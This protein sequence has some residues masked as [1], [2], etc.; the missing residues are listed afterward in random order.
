MNPVRSGK[1]ELTAILSTRY[2]NGG[3]AVNVGASFGYLISPSHQIGGT[4][5]FGIPFGKARPYGFGI[6]PSTVGSKKR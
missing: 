2:Y 1:F 5:V 4:L 3:V 6:R